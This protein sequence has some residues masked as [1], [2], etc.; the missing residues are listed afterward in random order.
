MM[1]NKV[2]FVLLSGGYYLSSQGASWSSGLHHHL[3]CQGSR[4]RTS[5]DPLLF[6]LWPMTHADKEPLGPLGS[7]RLTLDVRVYLKIRRHAGKEEED[8]AGIRIRND[9]YGTRERMNWFVSKTIKW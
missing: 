9:V 2:K 5:V 6:L 4:V 7:I 1:L 8:L 3:R